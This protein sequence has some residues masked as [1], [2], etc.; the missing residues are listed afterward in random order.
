LISASW[1]GAAANHRA[2][3]PPPACPQAAWAWCRSAA[4][5]AINTAILLA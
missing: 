1:L 4:R 2:A 5:R 3:A